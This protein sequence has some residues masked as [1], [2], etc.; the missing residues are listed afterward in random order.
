MKALR[1]EVAVFRFGAFRLDLGRQEL[2]R[3]GELVPLTPK[4]FDTLRMLVEAGGAVVDKEH[5]LAAIWR[6]RF[7]EESVLSQNVYTLRKVLGEVDGEG[8]PY[9]VTVPRRGYRLGVGVE[10]LP[11]SVRTPSGTWPTSVEGAGSGRPAPEAGVAAANG[12]AGSGGAGGEL[13][14]AATGPPTVE[15]VGV[16]PGLPVAGPPAAGA[17]RGAT[18]DQRRRPGRRGW[19]ALGVA[20]VLATALLLG[21][22]ASAPPADG[23]FTV[24]SLAVLPVLAL[25]GGEDAEMLGLAMADALITR[26]SQLEPLVVRPTSAVQE[27]RGPGRD[28]V[29]IGRRLQ[30]DAVMDGSLQRSGDRLRVSL[31][32]LRVDDAST[33]WAGNF[34]TVYTDPFSVQDLVS[35]QVAEAFSLQVAGRRTRQ[36]GNR[37]TADPEAYQ[38]YVR[39]RYFWNR[40]TEPDLRKAMEHFRAAL[41]RDPAFAAAHAGI[42]D[43]WAVLPLYS[44]VPPGEAFPRAIAAA[45]EALRLDPELAEAHTSLAYARFLY[46]WSWRDAEEGFRRAQ[47]LDPGYPTA[48]HWYAYLLS[49]LGRHDE[50][51][52]QARLAQQL[53]PLSLVINADLGLVLYFA[54]RYDDAI[55]QFQRA[56][57]LDPRFAYARFGLALALSAAGRHDEAVREGEQAVELAAGS[58]VNEAVRGFALGRAGRPDEARQVLAGLRAREPRV[59]PGAFALLHL[60]LD[61]REAALL[62]LEKALA[63]RSR[64]VVFLQVWPVYDGVRDDPRFAA[65]IHDVGLPAGRPPATDGGGGE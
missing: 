11:A 21:W 27:L 47:R 34:E 9:I 14:S 2:R 10:R 49:A 43:S 62:W 7:V 20:L 16:V 23:A 52:A 46:E 60:G 65:L 28:A 24:R 36:L 3:G 37:G 33:L 22:R 40:R 48:P 30:V 54:R 59:Q 56:I 5:I 44:S 64:F 45:G 17:S 53:D 63:E 55:A 32:L 12:A 35:G 57:E 26:L 19:F 61:D 6:D 8:Q 42:A 50:A 18:G 58:S 41:G 29:A 1:E 13:G 25:S 39:G 15:L 31:R 51:V 4:A 38:D